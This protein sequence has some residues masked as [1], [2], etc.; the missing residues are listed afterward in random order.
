MQNGYCW[1]HGGTDL[2]PAQSAYLK[3]FENWL[4]L[5]TRAAM[6]LRREMLFELMS[7]ARIPHRSPDPRRIRKLL[8]QLIPRRK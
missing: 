6:D 4:H 2:T 3:A 1:Y 7:E 5:P 8:A